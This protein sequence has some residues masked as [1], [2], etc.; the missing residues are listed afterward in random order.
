MP[1]SVSDRIRSGVHAI[2]AMHEQADRRAA[3][4]HYKKDV[5]H[6]EMIDVYRVIQLWEQDDPALQ[7]ALK[8]ILLAGKRGA[9][10]WRKDVQEAIDSCQRALDMEAE[11]RRQAV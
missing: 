1:D 4:G 2:A 6:L 8:K 9:K 7:H 11:D 10:D 3:H 5:R